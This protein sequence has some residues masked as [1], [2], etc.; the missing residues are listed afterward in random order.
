LAE[1]SDYSEAARCRALVIAALHINLLLKNISSHSDCGAK[2]QPPNFSTGLPR[3]S[4]LSLFFSQLPLNFAIAHYFDTLSK[5]C[6]ATPREAT[7]PLSESKRISQLRTLACQLLRP[8][9]E[10]QAEC[11]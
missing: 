9:E 5:I 2:R 11:F 10:A 6:P 1:A 8:R 4:S 7:A 3:L